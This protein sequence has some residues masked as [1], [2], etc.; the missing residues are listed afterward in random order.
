MQTR[1]ERVNLLPWAF[2]L[3][4]FLS[5]AQLFLIQP[6]FAK[7]VLPILGGAPAV[8]T[9]CMLFYQCLLLLG[10]LWAHSITSRL[11]LHRQLCLQSLI[12]ALPLLSFSTG[13]PH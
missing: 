10:Y 11:T 5:S 1:T 12:I 4:V 6:L 2:V 8:W 7:R 3:S 9:A 13:P